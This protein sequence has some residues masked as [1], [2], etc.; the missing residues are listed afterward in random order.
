M[1]RRRPHLH[2]RSQASDRETEARARFAA[3]NKL[4][5]ATERKSNHACG[6]YVDGFKNRVNIELI[7][8]VIAYSV[9]T[10]GDMGKWI[11]PL[12]SA[13]RIS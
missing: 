10:S 5:H 12:N 1:D 6:R 7:G 2:L 9:A 8:D 13:H 3:P 11:V 4:K